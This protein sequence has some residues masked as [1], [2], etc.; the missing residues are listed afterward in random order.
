[1]TFII[2]EAGLSF[3]GSLDKALKLVDAAKDAGADAVKFQSFLP[4]FDTALARFTLTRPE[5][6]RVFGHALDSKIIFMSTAFDRWAFDMLKDMGITHWKIP[7]GEL[8]NDL[9]LG[10]IPAQARFIY[11]STGM[12]TDTEIEHALQVLP[13]PAEKDIALMYCVSGYPTIPAQL[14]LS[15]ITYW[16]M[17]Q[18]PAYTV[19][20]SDH[21]TH[22][23]QYSVLA[24]ALGAQILEKHFFLDSKDDVPDKMVGIDPG[25]LKMYVR[26]IRE[27][28]GVLGDGYKKCQPCEEPTKK[29]R[30]RFK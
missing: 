1:V 5:W 18:Y 26:A 25:F 14:N 29:A 13:N 27:V 30:N 28:E 4:S 11:L 12:A 7:S 2:A 6:E 16:N 10:A 17:Q 9:Y 24:V 8:T 19:G 15:T 21:S 3:G 23:C 22:W 20:F